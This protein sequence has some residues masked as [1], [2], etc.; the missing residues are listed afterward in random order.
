MQPVRP[1]VKSSAKKA[2]LALEPAASAGVSPGHELECRVA[3]FAEK[4]AAFANVFEFWPMAETLEEHIERRLQSPQHQFAEWFTG[5]VKGEV[6]VSMGCFPQQFRFGETVAD[7]FAIAAVHTRPE[8]RGNGFAPQLIE[9]VEQY[10]LERER[11]VSILY[12]DIRPEYY[13]RLGYVEWPSFHGSCDVDKWTANA[14]VSKSSK[15]AGLALS[16]VEFSPVNELD[17]LISRYA[18]WTRTDSFSILRNEDYW[19]FLVQRSAKDIHTWIQNTDGEVIGYA[20]LHAKRG[21]LSADEWQLVDFAIHPQHVH[22]EGEIHD[23]IFV[24]AARQRIRR[25]SGWMPDSPEVHARYSI[26]PRPQEITMIK[27]LNSRMAEVTDRKHKFTG[28]IREID[29]V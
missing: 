24:E 16:V 2:E 28:W 11:T 22:A 26:E 21:K 3:D 15:A 12:S 1:D 14:G 10:Y 13:A 23:A 17:S 19:G 18:E 8:A 9:W 29:H 20:R 4:R 7:G 25:V 27:P 5:T 6:M